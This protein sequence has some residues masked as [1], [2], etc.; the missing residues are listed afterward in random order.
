MEVTAPRDPARVRRM[1]ESIAGRY[2]LLNRVL[3]AGLDVRW[4]R[5]TARWLP[6]D[7]GAAVLDLCG[8]T[9]DLTLAIE[10]EGRAGRVVCCD[11]SHSML[12]RAER[13]FRRRAPAGRCVTVEGDGL[14]LPF[15]DATFDGVTVAFGVR[16]LADVDLGFREML[17]VLRPGAA[18]VVLEFS[19]PTAPVLSSLYRLYLDRVLPRVGDT[20][21]GES[22]PYGYLA[23]TIAGFPPP[24]ILA[25]RIRDA[26]FA[27]CEWRTRTGGIVALHRAF[28]APG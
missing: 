9:G 7:A 25:G 26:G 23:R 16:N 20:V 14:R 17:R 22:G 3:S 4:R 24:D 13:K 19:R 1:F 12:A 18:L 21:S 8:G 10:R 2:D 11:F 15:P 6:T 5:E 27:A 28:R